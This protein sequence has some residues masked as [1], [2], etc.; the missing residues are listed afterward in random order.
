MDI[1]KEVK[2]VLNCSGKG[3]EKWL[4]PAILKLWQ[5]AFFVPMLREGGNE[6]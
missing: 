2:T 3:N 4:R 6:N 5:K 1:E